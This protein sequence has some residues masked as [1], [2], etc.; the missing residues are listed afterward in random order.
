[1]I[2]SNNTDRFN[3]QNTVGLFSDTMHN[4]DAVALALS[5][6]HFLWLWQIWVYRSAQSTIFNFFDIQA[7]WRS[8]LGATV[9]ECQKIKNDGLDQYG[10]EHFEV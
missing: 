5:V 4:D 3:V 8:V 1:M 7:I 10:P 6:P 2:E 9:P